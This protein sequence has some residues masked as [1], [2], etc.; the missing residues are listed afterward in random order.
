M[1]THVR[2]LLVLCAAVTLVY[3][4]GKVAP[5]A[6]ANC[7]CGCFV[8]TA[9]CMDGNTYRTFNL[10]VA[11]PNFWDSNADPSKTPWT[12]QERIKTDYQNL[13]NCKCSNPDCQYPCVGAPEGGTQGTPQ[14]TQM[15]TEC[16][17]GG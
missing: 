14:P 15:L 4:V 1:K 16:A 13:T 10:P 12:G 8:F 6:Q 17:G 11:K 7:N 2:R 5:R 3:Y 9:A